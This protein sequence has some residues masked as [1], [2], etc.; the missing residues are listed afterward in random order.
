MKDFIRSLCTTC[1][2]LD[3]CSL[4]ADKTK[5]LVCNEYVHRLDDSREPAIMVTDEM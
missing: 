2:Y 5:T 1:L 3:N 4:S